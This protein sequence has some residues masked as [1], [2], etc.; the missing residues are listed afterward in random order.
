MTMCRVLTAALAAIW[1]GFAGPASAQT[2]AEKVLL[3]VTPEDVAGVVQ[4]AGFRAKIGKTSDGLHQIS[5]KTQGIDFYI[6]V[7]D[8]DT[9]LSK[10]C[11]TLTFGAYLAPNT[12]LTADAMNQWNADRKFTRAFVDEAGDPSLEMDVSTYGVTH[13]YLLDLIDVW[14]TRVGKFLDHINW[15]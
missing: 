1:V 4:E 12:K 5:S 13:K 15:N 2:E 11:I 6:Y 7:V 8:C 9:N 3:G 10:D 14:D